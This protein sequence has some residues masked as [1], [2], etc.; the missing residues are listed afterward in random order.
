MGCGATAHRHDDSV[1]PRAPAGSV[2]RVGDADPA[3]LLGQLL[4]GDALSQPIA[5]VTRLGIPD[6][7]EG[8]PRTTAELAL[9][10]GANEDALHRVL[11]ALTAAGVLG[12][13][14]PRT[15]ALT[16]VSALLRR[17]VPGSMHAYAVVAGAPWRA[18]AHALM[19][20]VR[21][22][23]PAFEHMF[24]TTLYEFLS[25]H[26]EEAAAFDA[27]QAA[28]WPLLDVLP[29][30]GDL[31]DVRVIVD[32]GGGRGA[33]LATLLAG[34]PEARGVVVDLPSA[35][36]GARALLREAGLEAR[37]EFVAGDFFESV[38]RGGD[39]YLLAFV[40]HNWDDARASLVL[41]RCREAMGLEARLLVVENLL[42]EAGAAGFE[43]M[44]DVEMMI[45][46]AG[47]RERTQA[48]YRA[49]LARAGLTLARSAP[50][51]G[52]LHVL[53]ARSA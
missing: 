19:H 40:L 28:H 25:Q 23:Q 43:A 34:L 20:T 41:E 13:P 48:E 46:T 11:R 36:E 35:C 18:A 26:P 30:C 2:G 42:P 21:T 32:V 50:M 17:G 1:A 22:G 9:A 14:A 16:P 33:L 5:I 3:N 8:G 15:F 29:A 31:S 44:L 24:G 27:V 45:Y 38:P 6:L 52:A 7:L 4:T 47:G 53:E 37:A 39:V 12:E 51:N 49:L 10:V